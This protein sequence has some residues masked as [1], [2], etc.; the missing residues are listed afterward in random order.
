[1]SSVSGGASK[2]DMD[3]PWFKVV[4]DNTGSMGEACDAARKA[5]QELEALMKIFSIPLEISVVG[6]FDKSTPNHEH[7]GYTLPKSS[8]I[9]DINKFMTT[10]MKPCGGGGYPEAYRTAFNHIVKDNTKYQDGGSSGIVFVIC[11]NV[12]H[13]VNTVL[14]DNE[15]KLEEEYLVKHNMITNWDTLCATVRSLN[16]RVVTFLTQNASQYRGVWEK[17]GDVVCLV[18]NRSEYIT[19]ALMNVFNMITTQPFTPQPSKFT[20]G[21]VE[22]VMKLNIQE[23][24]DNADPSTILGI[25]SKL[26]DPLNPLSAVCLMTNLVIGKFWRNICGRYRFMNGKEFEL[27]CI[28]VINKLSLC[29]DKLPEP[30]K[31]QFKEWLD[32]SH[33]NTCQIREIIGKALAKNPTQFIVLEHNHCT[34]KFSPD[35]I[36]G[37]SRG[38][39]FGKI[40]GMINSFKVVNLHQVSLPPNEDEPPTFIPMNMKSIQVFRLMANLMCPGMMFSPTECFLV[41]ILSLTNKNL[42]DI[43]HSFLS[44]HV[45]KWISWKVDAEGKQDKPVF[46]S[47][48]FMLL[49]KM[50]PDELVSPQEILFRDHYLLVST[51]LRN[52]NATMKIMVSLF[53]E[54]LREYNTYKIT[55]PVEKG[56]CGQNRCFTLFPGDSDVCALCLNKTC[57]EALNTVYQTPGKIRDEKVEKANWAQCSTCNK[58]YTVSLAEFLNVRPKCHECRCHLHSSFITCVCC[59]N[60]FNSVANSHINAMKIAQDRFATSG[61]SERASILTNALVKGE[62]VCPLCVNTKTDA[63]MEV[64]VKLT[65]FIAENSCLQKV[66]PIG[67]YA[68]LVKNDPFWKRVTQ[69]TTF[70]QEESTSPSSI[71]NLTHKSFP[72]HS[73][74]HVA[75]NFQTTL[76]SHSG[77]DTCQLCWEEV[78]VYN[79]V[80]TCGNCKNLACKECVSTWYSQVK[81]GHIAKSGQCAC[82]FCKSPPSYDTVKHCEIRLI[83]NLRPS[84][85]NKGTVCEWDHTSVY[86]VCRYCLN[87]RHAFDQ[88]CGRGDLPNITDFVCEECRTSRV[89]HGAKSVDELAIKKCPQCGIDVERNGGCKHISCHCGAHWCWSCG[90]DHDEDGNPFDSHSVYDHL[91]DVCG[92]IFD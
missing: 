46:W 26:L 52:I 44:Q 13:G 29:K 70:S 57:D 8:S 63:I 18:Q 60:K 10:Y 53:F 54:G 76:V 19:S 84:K 20:C 37:L 31:T 81:I 71:K 86:G 24:I 43:A 21:N 59:L 72:V 2:T 1:M 88:E 56:G 17:M 83:K 67:P 30:Y 25:F 62:F 38:E 45:G 68:S 12:P 74:E 36:K 66:V 79:I 34:E 35:D 41:A 85:A 27:R 7:G 91:A 69:C 49:L 55:C 11:D 51:I 58:M 23:I 39:E 77:R 89:L 9:A 33:N 16:I 61:D 40:A 14:L 65:D 64:D 42:T 6:D 78:P 73:P 82:P 4:V 32:A 5:Y 90:A 28:D 48:N 47:K 3:L 92:G 80:P 50:A 75:Q 15:G 87:L 22:P